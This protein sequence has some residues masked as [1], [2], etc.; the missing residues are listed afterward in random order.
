MK[1]R[2]QS[3][4]TIIVTDVALDEASSGRRQSNGEGAGVA[5]L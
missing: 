3:L 1:L 5:Q 2:T 4:A